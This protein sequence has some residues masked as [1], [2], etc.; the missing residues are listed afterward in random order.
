MSLVKDFNSRY[1]L[2]Q[3]YPELFLPELRSWVQMH[4]AGFRMAYPA[5]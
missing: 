4:P 2:K 5:R 3:S 1:E